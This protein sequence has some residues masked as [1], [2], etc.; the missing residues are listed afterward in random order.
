SAKETKLDRYLTHDELDTERSA[1]VATA[2]HKTSSARSFMSLIDLAYQTAQPIADLLALN[3]QD[4]SDD[5]NT[6]RPSQTV[7]RRSVRL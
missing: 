1:I 2:D 4:V 7:N 3:T 6:L 5:G